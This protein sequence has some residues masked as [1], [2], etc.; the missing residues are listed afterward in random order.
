M[1][2]RYD[3][4]NI[5]YFSNDMIHNSKKFA[6]C[7]HSVSK[8]VAVVNLVEGSVR[9]EQVTTGFLLMTQSSDSSEVWIRGRISNLK[10]GTHGFHVHTTGST[11]SECAGA[12]SHFNPTNVSLIENGKI[13]WCV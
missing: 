11:D 4:Y 5:L 1:V 3:K 7:F 6:L 8:I 10:A 2:S 9:D 12:G 13:G